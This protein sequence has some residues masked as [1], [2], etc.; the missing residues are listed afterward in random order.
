MATDRLTLT[1]QVRQGN[2]CVSRAILINPAV[3]ERAKRAEASHSN[4]SLRTINPPIRPEGIDP[5]MGVVLAASSIYTS[6]EIYAKNQDICPLSS[7]NWNSPLSVS[8]CLYISS[9]TFG[10][11][12][13]I[14]A[15]A[16]NA[17]PT[18][19][20]SLMLAAN[21]FVSDLL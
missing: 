11:M 14:C 8:T 19:A 4:G 10:G 9:N 15:P 6:S 18:V 1:H 5:P 13:Q 3:R 17:L 12:V 7:I 20:A 16:A 2:A 21:I